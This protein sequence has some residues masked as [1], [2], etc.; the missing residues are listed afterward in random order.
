MRLVP[1]AA[2][3]TDAGA[4][5]GAEDNVVQLSS[6]PVSPARSGDSPSPDRGGRGGR[7][8]LGGRGGRGAYRGCGNALG[9]QRLQPYSG[10]SELR[11]APRGGGVA[12]G[13]GVSGGGAA[14]HSDPIVMVTQKETLCWMCDHNKKQWCIFMGKYGREER[15][16][17]KAHEA[18]SIC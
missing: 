13:G 17:C 4:D 15:W 10:N 12:R 9:G 3:G 11:G 2:G 1:H 6:G 7:G 18:D 5:P 16:L 14:R 8:G